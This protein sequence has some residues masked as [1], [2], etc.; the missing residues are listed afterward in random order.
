M[1]IREH[2][3]GVMRRWGDFG[4]LCVTRERGLCPRPSA[5]PGIFFAK[6]K[7][8]VRVAGRVVTRDGKVWHH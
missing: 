8:K 3:H 2:V 7:R 4:A 5:S 1:L 6:K